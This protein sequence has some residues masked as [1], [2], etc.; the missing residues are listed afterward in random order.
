MFEMNLA[1]R[2]IVPTGDDSPAGSLMKYVWRMSGTHQVWVCLLAAGVASLSM[3]PLELQRRIV[4]NAVGDADLDLLVMFGAI[5]LGALL[6]QAFL[7]F[8]L[9]VYQGWLGES[10]VRYS[11]QHLAR[12]HECRNDGSEEDSGGQAVSVIG[13]EI[14]KLGG[15]VGEGLSQP[16]VNLGIVVSVFGFMVVVEPTIA[17]LSLPFFA[18]QLLAIAWAQRAINKLVER[19]V[20]MMREMSDTI[21]SLPLDCTDIEDS[22]LP[23]QLQ[24]IYGNRM[25]TYVL[26]FAAKALA[27]LMN[28]LAPLSALVIGGYLVIQGETTLGVVV[29]FISGFDRLANP[30]RELIAY[31]RVVAQ[32]AVQHRMIANWM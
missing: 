24:S 32:A 5:Y 27:N 23:D 7:K 12:I 21:T 26:K 2:R 20:S 14:E 8:G 25:K 11:R 4:N 30:L 29:A 17:L 16:V 18:P 22:E 3:V 10:A 1:P 15:F 31:Y 9:R 28:G 13:A 6:L 19:R